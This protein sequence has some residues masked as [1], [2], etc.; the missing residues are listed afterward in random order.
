[1][2]E[3]LVVVWSG[4][5]IG[6]TSPESRARFHLVIR[7][8]DTGTRIGIMFSFSLILSSYGWR[9]TSPAKEY[10]QRLWHP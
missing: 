5:V 6:R 10:L 3:F 4:T 7:Y 1:L 8:H 9:T 2:V